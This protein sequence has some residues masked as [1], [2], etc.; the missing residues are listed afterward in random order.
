MTT[1]ASRKSALK[2]DIKY[3]LEE[4]WEAEEEEPF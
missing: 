3:V 1:R 2:E 4:L